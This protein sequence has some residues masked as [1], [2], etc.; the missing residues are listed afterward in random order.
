M[1]LLGTIALGILVRELIGLIYP[2]GRNP[3]IFP[4]L[5]PKG[6]LIP[7]SALTS[8][9]ML[10]IIITLVILLV[11]FFLI[12]R[13]RLGWAMQTL[14][15]D[16]ETAGMIGINIRKSDQLH[17]L[18]GRR[19]SWYR[20]F[21]DRI[22]LRNRQIRYGASYGLMDIPQRLSED[23]EIFTAPLSAE[24]YFPSPKF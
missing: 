1:P 17:L 22:L 20:R 13:T 15:Q 12:N 10:I 6:I 14:S 4:S 2:Q 16:K 11:L 5:L 7:G 21:S 3:Q 19:Y 18:S 23:L 9:N 24:W 8:A